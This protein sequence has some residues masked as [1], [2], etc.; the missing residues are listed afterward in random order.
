MQ[1]AD[2][3]STSGQRWHWT[4]DDNGERM[5]HIVPAIG[6]PLYDKHISEAYDRALATQVVNGQ[7]KPVA[8]RHRWWRDG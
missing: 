3:M 1:G 5:A 7:D 4:Q 2:T 8:G 6:T